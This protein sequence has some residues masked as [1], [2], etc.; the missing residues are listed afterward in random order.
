MAKSKSVTIHINGDPSGLSSGL[1]DAAGELDSFAGGGLAKFGVAAAAGM[2]AAA[3]LAGAA[4]VKGLMD[5]IDNEKVYD[6]LSAQLG[7]EDGS[8]QAEA[9]GQV[10]GDLYSQ[11]Y[12]ESLGDVA[13]TAWA[14][15]ASLGDALGPGSDGVEGAIVAAS[16]LA[17]AYGLA[18]EDI[19]GTVGIFEQSGLGTV[20]DGFD[21]LAVAIGR[22]GPALK[23]D[24]VQ[25]VQ[26]YSP[27]AAQ[28]GMSGEEFVGMLAEAGELGPWALDKTGDALKE[29]TIRATDM[30]SGTT[31]AFETLGLDAQQMANDVL[32]GG[33][34][35][36]GAFGLIVDRLLGME[37]P[38]ARANTAIALF[39]TPLED[40]TTEQIPDFLGALSDGEGSLGE[41]EGAAG[42]LGEA[43]N[44]NAGTKIEKFKRTVLMGLSG[45]FEDELLPA[46][47]QGL[48]L[49]AP[50]ADGFRE[51]GVDGLLAAWREEVWPNIVAGLSGFWA[52]NGDDILTGIVDALKGAAELYA[53]IGAA[54]YNGLSEALPAIGN[55][56]IEEAW[57]YIQTHWQGWVDAFVGFVNPLIAELLGALGGMI[58]NV[59]IWVLTE[60]IPAMAQA[61]VDMGWGLMKWLATDAIPEGIAH[62]GSL[63]GSIADWLTREA[64][65]RIG[66]AAAGMWDGIAE[67]FRGMLNWIIGKW[68]DL[69]FSTPDFPGT[70]W[71]GIDW[72]SPNIATIPA[73]AMGGPVSA[74]RPYI[75]GERGPEL[76]VP[77]GSGQIVPNH[78]MGNQPINVTVEFV[79]DGDKLGSQTVRVLD[80]H[81][82][83][84]RRN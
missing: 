52:E 65:G 6:R 21:L 16:D 22:V 35:A 54:L 38:A 47:G 1:D 76:F 53:E 72:N 3:A 26:E 61:G 4:F 81:A 8:V 46:M 10:T 37:D 49:L 62:I 29:F 80:R 24:L 79:I 83:A 12:G 77:H 57:P 31:A 66:D 60:G 17:A 50:L 36:D 69:S 59:G 64:P 75:V 51:S 67:A 20:T 58:W 42:R 63:I 15:N 18:A 43:L 84:R 33:E 28:L 19:V 82:R 9:W 14:V 73:R 44:D 74:S 30:S 56:L 13:N 68:N 40:L 48:D 32:A 55:W 5:A 27:F 41:F 2:A 34:Q 11:A 39:G 45:F 25:A 7:L 71:G 78:A 70:D 23:D